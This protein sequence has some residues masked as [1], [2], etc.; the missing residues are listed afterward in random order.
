MSNIYCLLTGEGASPLPR[1]DHQYSLRKIIRLL[2]WKKKD[3]FSKVKSSAIH[4]LTPNPNRKRPNYPGLASFCQPVEKN[5]FFHGKNRTGKN[6][7][8]RQKWVFAGKNYFASKNRFLT[9]FICITR[10]LLYIILHSY[11]W[12][13]L[14]YLVAKNMYH[15][16]HVAMC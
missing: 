3:R 5:G 2:A 10:K 1:P 4:V 7:F 16:L 15:C 11:V 12:L 13:L 6:S 14:I 8:C 9:I